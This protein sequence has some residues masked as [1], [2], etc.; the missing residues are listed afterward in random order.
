VNNALAEVHGIGLPGLQHSNGAWAL[1]KGNEVVCWKRECECRVLS[2]MC[3]VLYSHAIVGAGAL[4][5]ATYTSIVAAMI[6][7]MIMIM[8][9]MIMIASAFTICIVK[10][11]CTRA[12]FVL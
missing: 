3:R 9:I 10:R 6:M 11:I 8:I 4:V 12:V 1:S 2:A 7:I 5:V